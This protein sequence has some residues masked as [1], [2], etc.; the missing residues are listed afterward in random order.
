VQSVDIADLRLLLNILLGLTGHL[1]L[2]GPIHKGYIVIPKSVTPSRIEEN[3]SL[4]EQVILYY[5]LRR[6]ALWGSR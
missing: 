2:L 4:G 1:L 6:T 3:G 5:T